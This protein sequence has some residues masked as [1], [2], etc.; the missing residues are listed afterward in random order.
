MADASPLS[1]DGLVQILFGSSAFQMLNAGRN[2]G[3][4]ALL[5]RQPGLTA[6]EIGRELGLAERPVQILLL[7]TTAL[8]LTTRQGEG[9]ANAGLL[10]ALF[11]DGTWEIIEDLIEYEERIV[12]P[13]EV[14]FTQSLRENTNVGLRR[15]KGTGPDLYHRLSADPGLEQLFYRCMRSWSRLSNPVLVGKADLKGVRRVLDVGGG[16]G[17]NAIALARANPGVE[18]T[19]LDLPGTAEI[20][21]R[22]IAEHGL[23]DR[24]SVRAADIFADTYPP[25]HDCV[26]FA[27]QLVIWSPEENTSL[28]RKAYAALPDGGRVLVFNAMSDDSGDG[29]LYAALD[30]VYFATLPARSSTIY[31]WDQYE[32]WFAAAGFVKS[33]RLPGGRWTPHGVISAVK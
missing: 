27:N 16:D 14:D 4:F 30:N 23:S 12:R 19:V 33:E 29:P 20:A 8:R 7:G 17:V 26:L 21:R 25:G 31:R 24:I 13:A 2:L 5:H 22:R 1:T 10:D 15:I 6:G 32:E 18:F 28:L 11:A 3:L 9:Y